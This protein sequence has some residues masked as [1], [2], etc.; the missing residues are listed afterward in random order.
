MRLLSPSKAVTSNG[1]A[2]RLCD[3][4]I[5]AHASLLPLVTATLE[6]N[7]R[8]T[9]ESIAS[10][11]A[12]SGRPSGDVSL[13]AVT[14]SVDAQMAMGLV[15]LG[16][17]DLGENR[18]ASLLAKREFFA[19]AGLEANWHYIGQIQRNKARRVLQNSDVLHSVDTLKLIDTLER[20]AAEENRRPRIYLEV[21]LSDDPAKH[22][23]A[24]EGLPA[25]VQ[26]AGQC[27]HLELLGLMGMASRR[28]PDAPDAAN[29]FEQLAALAS[30]LEADPATRTCFE[31]GRVRLSMGMS[32]DFPAAIAAGSDL[33][34]IG[35]ALFQGLVQDPGSRGSLR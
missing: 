27:K 13:L 26:R 3:P 11:A 21:K 17:R 5:H 1:K 23:F 6:S 24:P 30:E 15:R 29:E 12:L 18:L 25:A 4:I 9:L 16:Q 20:L 34:R 31:N 2:V 10:A 35:T 33:V 22:G 28:E 32:G 14:K 19:S 8:Q 7:L